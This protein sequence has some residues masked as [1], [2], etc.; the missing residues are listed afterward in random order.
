M[1]YFC[2]FQG[3][4]CL[5]EVAR[6]E[7]GRGRV[8]ERAQ[9]RG[10]PQLEPALDGRAGIDPYHANPEAAHHSECEQAVKSVRVN[11]LYFR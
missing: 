4:Q 10:E 8:H 6:V 7:L 11:F 3:G 9:W 1:D 5:S 2:L